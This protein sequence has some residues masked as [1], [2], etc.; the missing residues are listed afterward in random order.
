MTNLVSMKCNINDNVDCDQSRQ[1][2]DGEGDERRMCCQL[3]TR[4]CLFLICLIC[5][6]FFPSYHVNATCN[7]DQF[8]GLTTGNCLQE[9]ID[10]FCKRAGAIDGTFP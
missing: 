6:F 7:Y 5:F 8:V 1:T 4:L 10:R 9:T 3:Y 2:N